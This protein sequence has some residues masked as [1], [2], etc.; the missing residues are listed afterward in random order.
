MFQYRIL[1][2]VAEDGPYTDAAFETN[3]PVAVGHEI[4]WTWNPENPKEEMHLVVTGVCHQEGQ[5][6]LYCE[7]DDIYCDEYLT[8]TCVKLGMPKHEARKK[9]GYVR[10]MREER[11]KQTQGLSKK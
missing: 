7:Y 1:L 9:H 5:T 3:T 6:I 10:E 11:Y 4:E 8:A 2:Y